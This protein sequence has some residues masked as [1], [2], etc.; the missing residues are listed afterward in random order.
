LTHL[1]REHALTETYGLFLIALLISAVAILILGVSSGFVT[2][3]L[4]KPPVFAVQIKVISPSADKQVITLYHMEGEPVAFSNLSAAGAAAP[5]VFFTL[6]SPYREKI[7]VYP[8]P[9][10]T[11]NLWTKGGTA[12]LY[13]DGSRFRV[14]DDLATLIAKKGSGAIKD[15]PSGIWIVYIT[16]QK[17]QV[18][19]N[20]LTVTV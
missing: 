18:I 16:D 19:V 6:E 12:T 4:Q 5:G 1:H 3:V 20:S 10:M 15:M 11:G 2:S 8:S 17:T 7:A 9:V 14:T 13:Y